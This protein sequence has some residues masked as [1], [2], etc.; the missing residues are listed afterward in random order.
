MAA[1][2]NEIG[3]TPPAE[4]QWPQVGREVGYSV[5]LNNPTYTEPVDPG[6]GDG[7]GL[8]ASPTAAHPDFEIDGDGLVVGESSGVTTAGDLHTAA[9]PAVEP[10]PEPVVVDV[11]DDAPLDF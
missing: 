10:E 2:D 6:R 5:H 1:G 9:A 3:V 4:F 11:V 7:E 8:P